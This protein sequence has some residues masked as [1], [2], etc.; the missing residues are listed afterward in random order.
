MSNNGINEESEILFEF[1]KYE[2]YQKALE[3]AIKM[4]NITRNFPNSEQFGLCSQLRRAA[5]SIP[6]NLAEGF[7]NYYKKEKKRYYRIARGSI[8]E[9]VP[10]LAISLNQNFIDSCDHKDMYKESFGL[11][12]RIA[13][14]I[15]SVDKRLK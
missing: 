11:S 13:G 10:A 12:R 8:H 9:C 5:L 3:Y 2:I 4:Y 1:E 7:C 14:L 6:L 15:R